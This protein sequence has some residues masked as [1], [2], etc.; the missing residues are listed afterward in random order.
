MVKTLELVFRNESGQ[1][2]TLSLADPKDALT[3]AEA[4]TVMQ[5]IIAKN[6]F[7][8]KG[9]DLTDAVDARVRSRDT[10]SLA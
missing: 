6:I 1:E 9:G 4:Q 5:D 10:V 7:T 3:K 8:S 2:V